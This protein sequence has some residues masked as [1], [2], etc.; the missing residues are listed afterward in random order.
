MF[1]PRYRTD[2]LRTFGELARTITPRVLYCRLG[3]V[4]YEMQRKNPVKI[5]NYSKFRQLGCETRRAFMERVVDLHYC[6]VD[7]VQQQDFLQDIFVCLSSKIV[8][9]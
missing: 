2:L 8:S 6:R 7:S 1:Q 5:A 4:I 9:S 3:R